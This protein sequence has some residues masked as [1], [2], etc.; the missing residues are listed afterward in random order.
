M[1][2]QRLRG[3]GTNDLLICTQ[4]LS[5]RAGVCIRPDQPWSPILRST[6]QCKVIKNILY[7]TLGQGGKTDILG[8]G[9]FSLVS[10]G[11]GK[12]KERRNGSVHVLVQ[13]A[14]FSCKGPGC[15]YFRHWGASSLS[16]NLPNSTG[17]A[18]EQPRT[19]NEVTVLQYNFLCQ[20]RW[21]ARFDPQDVVC[22]PQIQR[23]PWISNEC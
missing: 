12:S 13:S 4:L 5:D 20:N 21:L 6:Y 7:P 10:C 8:V 17:L 11:T 3:G 22:W 1:T 15:Q 9:S 16:W 14:N 23:T 18:Q 19:M 2:N